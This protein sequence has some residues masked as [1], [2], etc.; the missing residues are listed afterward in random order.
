[1][2]MQ[3][4]TNP[5][6]AI[7]N[8]FNSRNDIG[9]WQQ[10]VGSTESFVSCCCMSLTSPL[11]ARNFTNVTRF[12]PIA[13]GGTRKEFGQ[14]YSLDTTH[15]GEHFGRGKLNAV[16]KW[17]RILQFGTEVRCCSPHATQRFTTRP[18]I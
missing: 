6:T 17:S 10:L 1:M 8:R 2:G 7:A 14:T 18:K 13:T 5:R 4:R 3:A 12:T 16:P 9:L 15:F 11:H